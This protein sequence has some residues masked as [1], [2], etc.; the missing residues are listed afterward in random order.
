MTKVV[1]Y[2]QQPLL[3]D[4]YNYNRF[5]GT[6]YLTGFVARIDLQQEPFWIVTLSDA[7]GDLQIYCRDQSCIFGRLLPQSL[8]NVE[9]GIDS[10]G[11]QP[12]FRCK[13]I[14]L[15]ALEIGKPKLLSQLPA[16]L[17]PKPDALN[18]LVDLVDSIKEPLLKEF[19][20]N[21]LLQPN[22]GL[23]FIQCPASIKHHHNYGGGLLE[24]SVEVA[25]DFAMHAQHHS[26]QRDLAIATGLLHDIG[27]TQTYTVDGQRTAIGQIINHDDLTLEI[28]ASSLQILSVSHAGFANQLRH[29]WTCESEGSRYGFKAKTPTARLLKVF[30]RNSASKDYN[31]RNSIN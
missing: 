15:S 9:A 4:V 11:K 13:F 30:D 5:K 16:A 27:K 26:E 3:C 22:I 2:N 28:C 1:A 10:S 14:Q 8:V 24:H 7:S 21:V 29:A 19:V 18:T 25:Q 20:C 31:E 17:C 6:Y 23:K 12:Y